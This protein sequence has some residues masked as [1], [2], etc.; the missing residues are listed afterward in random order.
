M[1]QQADNLISNGLGN[2]LFVL[3][4]Q[5]GCKTLTKFFSPSKGLYSLKAYLI[6]HE[7]MQCNRGK[8]QASV[9]AN[10]GPQTLQQ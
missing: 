8:A 9:R 10:T 3:Y 7:A 6:K 4:L 1:V 5:N 2:P